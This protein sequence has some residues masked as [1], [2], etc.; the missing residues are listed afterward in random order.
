MIHLFNTQTSQLEPFSTSSA[1]VGI[2]T[3]GIT[4]YDTTHL[5]HAFTYAV[6]DILIRYLEWVGFPVTYVQNVTDIDDD[7]LRKA[8]EVGED[9]RE[10]GNRWTAHFIQDMQQLNMRAPDFYPRATSWIPDIQ[11][12]VEK[13][14]E[15][16]KAYVK[17]GNVYFDVYSWDSFGELSGLSREEMLP[18]ANERGNTPDDPNK[19]HPLDFVLWQAQKP[20][21]PAWESPWGAGRPGWHIECSTMST[22]LIGDV[23]DIHLGGSDLLFPH[24]ECEIAQVEAME[25]GRNTFVR[26]WMH[27]AMVRHENEKMSKSLG[28]LVMISDLLKEYPADAIRIYLAMH[29]YRE[30]WDYN[31]EELNSALYQA[32]RIRTALENGKSAVSLEKSSAIPASFEEAMENDLDTPRALSSINQLVDEILE[33]PNGSQAQEARQA[34]KSMAAVMGLRR[35]VSEPDLEVVTGWDR[36][37][38]QFDSH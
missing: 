27:I 22:R 12:M 28:N 6:S 8:G 10:L 31:R 37:M 1:R 38:E 2:Y 14:V 16:G 5:G 36:H 17:N 20:G 7:I 32:R 21:E 30:S 15:N 13:L 11:K 26:Y 19:R 18:I 25:P 33:D 35:S 24:H 34:L 9:W 4:P 29:H 23:V 3:C